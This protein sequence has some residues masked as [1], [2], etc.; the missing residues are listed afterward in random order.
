MNDEDFYLNKLFIAESELMEVKRGNYP[1]NVKVK[2]AEASAVI[3]AYQTPGAAGF[4]FHAT[5]DAVI[6]VGGYAVINTGIAF[7]LPE[8]YELSVR[9][10]SGLAFKSQIIAFN[11]T[12]DSDFRDSVRVLLFNL[13][14]EPFY[15][16]SGERIAQGIINKIERVHFVESDELNSTERGENGFGSTG[17]N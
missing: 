8:G 3:P 12:V 6:P 2:K 10:R 13:S 16:K 14:A 15:I 17:K 9:G 11:G 1:M 4:D 5:H 7:E